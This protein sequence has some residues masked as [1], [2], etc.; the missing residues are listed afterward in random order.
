MIKENVLALADYLENEIPDELFDMGNYILR[1]KCGTVACIAGHE[2]IR[3]GN[4]MG[5][6]GCTLLAGE[7]YPS[8]YEKVAAISLGLESPDPFADELFAPRGCTF[9]Y[10]ASPGNAEHITRKHAIACLR[11]LAHT[12]KVDWAESHKSLA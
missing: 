11:R 4:P 7:Y 10:K 6:V 12:G 9:N 8:N 3:I 1:N 5:T 2:C